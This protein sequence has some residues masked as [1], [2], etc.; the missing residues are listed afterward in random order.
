MKDDGKE[1]E[2]RI[3]ISLLRPGQTHQAYGLNKVKV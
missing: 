1:S 2:K 3:F